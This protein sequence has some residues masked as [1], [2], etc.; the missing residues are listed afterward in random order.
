MLNHKKPRICCGVYVSENL[1]LKF[2]LQH[3]VP[4]NWYQALPD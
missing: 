2:I 3:F 4:R 1:F